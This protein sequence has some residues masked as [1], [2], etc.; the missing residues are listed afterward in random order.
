MSKTVVLEEFLEGQMVFK[1]WAKLLFM[2]LSCV[3][4]RR[5]VKE[6]QCPMPIVCPPERATRSVTLRFLEANALMRVVT[7][8]EGA[9]RLARVTF[10]VANFR[11]SLRPSG[12]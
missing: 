1:R 4:Y 2:V 10:R 12:T 11:L 6:V 7:L 5:S 8:E 9:G 3:G